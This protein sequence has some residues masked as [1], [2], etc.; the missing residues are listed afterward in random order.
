MLSGCAA[1]GVVA[2]SDPGQ[3]VKDAYAL[4]ERKQRPLPAERLIREAISMYEENQDDLGLAEAH[5]AYG[6]FFRSRAVEEWRKHY[7]GG[8][9]EPGAAF[10]NRFEKSVAHFNRAAEILDRHQ[11]HDRLAN[12]YLNGAITYEINHQPQQACDWFSKSLE[13]NARYLKEHPDATIDLPD[14]FASFEAF[15]ISRKNNLQ[16]LP[17]RRN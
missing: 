16:C 13:S 15:V 14:G 1:Y 10:A 11:R 17:D 5:R 2:T 3:K 6:F 7:E 9:L 8:F 4:F 12:I